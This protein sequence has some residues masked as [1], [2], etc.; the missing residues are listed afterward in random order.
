VVV[1]SKEQ[2]EDLTKSDPNIKEMDLA[3]ISEKE[4]FVRKANIV[5]IALFIV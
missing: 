2:L 1:D 5:M 4:V 3:A